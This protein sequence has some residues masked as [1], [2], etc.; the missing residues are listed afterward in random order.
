MRLQRIKDQR[1][2]HNRAYQERETQ[3]QA[4]IRNMLQ[5]Q[6]QEEL[7]LIDVKLNSTRERLEQKEKIKVEQLQMRSLKLNERNKSVSVR[8]QDTFRLREQNYEDFV[9]KFQ[10]DEKKSQQLLRKEYREIL[11][12]YNEYK[13]NKEETAQFTKQRLRE[14]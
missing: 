8:C 4:K 2:E 12:M 1:A 9:R 6:S 5:K 11:Q 3:R 14:E 13:A 7:A 10:E